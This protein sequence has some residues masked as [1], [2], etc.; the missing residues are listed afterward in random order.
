M[1]GT[2]TAERP[3]LGQ[4]NATSPTPGRRLAALIGA[5]VAIGV[6]ACIVLWEPWHGP[7][8]LSLSPTH[9][10]DLG[11]VMVI[12]F[13]ALAFFLV[14]IGVRPAETTTGSSGRW[15]GPLSAIVLGGLLLFAGATG[16][17]FDDVLIAAVLAAACW[18]AVELIRR[19]AAWLGA[20][21]RAWRSAVALL[22]VGGLL[23]LAVPPSGTVFCL[24]LLAAWFC[25][26]ATD[27]LEAIVGSLLIVV[28]GVTSLA[29]LDAVYDGDD[30]FLTR[31]D[32]GV[33]RA[34]ALGGLL[35]T[36]GLLR[37]RHALRSGSLA[38]G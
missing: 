21:S 8:L 12:P 28:L 24:V 31:A 38:T 25:A 22:L 6:A 17:M 1:S 19:R 33:A 10:V 13:V 14:S 23:D 29:S 26:T 15:V 9:G 27:R 20:R 11:D 4:L 16:L 34:L 36:V 3:G 5:L 35:M 37:A 30:G 18:F 32:G 7:T 2:R